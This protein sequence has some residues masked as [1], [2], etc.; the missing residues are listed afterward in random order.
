MSIPL[1]RVVAFVGP[2]ISVVAGGIAAYLVAVVDVI[3]LPGL[4]QANLTTWL[5]GAI[6][7]VVTAALSWLGHSKWLT[8]HHIVLQTE[9]TKALDKLGSLSLLPA[10][11][12]NSATGTA[13][14]GQGGTVETTIPPGVETD[15]LQPVDVDTSGQQST[16]G[17]ATA[18]TEPVIGA[19]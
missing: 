13:V 3:G 16:D 1:N 9:L 19:V 4:N 5:A 12:V 2:Y 14:S 6:T 17:D 7:F 18:P 11:T 10:L 15:P 8:G